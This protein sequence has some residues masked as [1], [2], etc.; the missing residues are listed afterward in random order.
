MHIVGIVPARMGSSRFPGKPLARIYGM[1][2]VGHVYLRSAMASSLD[3]VYIAT[4]D[5]EI[6]EY[7]ASIDAPAIMTA[8]THERASDRAAEAVKDVERSTGRPVDVVVMIQ[9]DEPMVTP[10]M[11]DAAV[12]ALVSDTRAPVVNLM[13]PIDDAEG[14]AD[15]NEIKVVTDLEDFALYFSRAPIP[16]DH[17]RGGSGTARKQICIIAFRREFLA[18]FNELRPTPLEIAESVDMMRVLEHGY[19]VKMVDAGAD[20]VSVDTPEDLVEVETLMCGEAL[21][22]R[23]LEGRR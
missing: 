6:T 9:G 4:C 16:H 11:I 17:G 1:P 2:M 13:G 3:A 10:V 15:P 12:Q 14:L 20:T 22:A 7:A 18:T 21:M 8:D 23:Y 19:R 5:G